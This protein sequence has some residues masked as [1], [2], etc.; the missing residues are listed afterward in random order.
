MDTDYQDK[1]M[2][3]AHQWVDP[4]TNMAQLGKRAVQHIRSVGTH[5]IA[6]LI[7]SALYIE[8]ARRRAAYETRNAPE[9]TAC[10]QF[11]AQTSTG[12]L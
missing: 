9:R 12:A 3:K 1:Q 4:L 6:R 2:V 7:E 5:G 11:P 10:H 8:S